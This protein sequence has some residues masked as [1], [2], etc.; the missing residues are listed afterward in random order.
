MGHTTKENLIDLKDELAQI[1][2]LLYIKEKS[3]GIFYWKS[4]PFLHFHDK[5]GVR[6]ADVKTNEG[7]KKLEIDFKANKKSKSDFIKAVK[8]HYK[9]FLSD[10]ISK[11]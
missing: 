2:E 5:D 3:P 7:W 1:A 9:Q 11:P 8:I 10:R 4:L 6:W